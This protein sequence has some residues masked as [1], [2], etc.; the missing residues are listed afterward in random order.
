MICEKKD[1]PYGYV[2]AERTNITSRRN[3]RK[4]IFKTSV[5]F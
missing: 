4:Y 2:L 1:G 3:Q 5:S